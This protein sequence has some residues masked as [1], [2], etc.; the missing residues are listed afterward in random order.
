MSPLDLV[1]PDAVDT[2]PYSVRL[3]ARRALLDRQAQSLKPQ[4]RRAHARRTAQELEWLESVRLT[5]GTGFDVRLID[6]SEGG[7]LLEVNAPLRPGVRLKLEISG[8]E[9]D[10][11]VSLE[12]LRCYVANLGGASTIYRGACAFERLIELPSAIAARPQALDPAL[13]TFVGTDAA[14]L[15]LHARA[16]AMDRRQIIQV[17]DALHLR[18]GTKNDRG[19]EHT[20][21]LL[22][23]ILPALHRA[24]PREDVISVLYGWLRDLPKHVQP[25][26]QDTSA[27]LL[28]LIDRC[29]PPAA[30]DPSTDAGLGAMASTAPPVKEGTDAPTTFQKIVVRYAD[31]GLGKGF[32]Q[33]FYPT[34]PQFSLWPSINASPSERVVVP[35]ARLK[36]VFFVKDFNGNP[37]YRERKSFTTR[38]QGRRVEVTFLDTEVILGTTLNYR[39]D[40]QGFFVNPVDPAANNTRIFVVTSAVKRVRFL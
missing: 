7:A 29:A 28:G 34:R 27:R 19:G 21:Q 40:G 3:A 14:L 6:L 12:V 8:R 24:A 36:A 38:G 23:A 10:A 22:A 33:D 20:G 26:M 5:G 16:H 4:E 15:Y 9:I 1:L 13:P 35:I 32:S 30:L 11:A 18:A 2:V 17:L 37:G 31:G 25:R 39:P